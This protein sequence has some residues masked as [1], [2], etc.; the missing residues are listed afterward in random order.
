MQSLLQLDYDDYEVVVID[1]RSTDDTGVI[2]DRI[3]RVQRCLTVRHITELPAGW[4]GKIHALAVGTEQST[5]DY[6]LFTDADVVMDRSALRHHALCGG[7]QR[8]PSS[9]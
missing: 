9:R 6:L 2:L 5:G 3:A 1:D 8:G 4:L 7:D